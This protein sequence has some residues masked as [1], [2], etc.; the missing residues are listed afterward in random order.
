MISP[1][2]HHT[3]HDGAPD[4]YASPM[5]SSIPR[6]RAATL[7][8]SR[9]TLRDSIVLCRIKSCGAMRSRDR[10]PLALFAA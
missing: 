5:R 8:I 1:M 4:D 10:K 2:H 7:L 9:K 6:L 3:Q